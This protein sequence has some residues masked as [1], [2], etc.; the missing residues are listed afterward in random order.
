MRWI[1][2]GK[3]YLRHRSRLVEKGFRQI[4]GVDYDLSHS[5]VLSEVAFRLLLLLSLQKRMAIVTID[6]EKS[7]LGPKVDENLYIS[8]PQGLDKMMDIM[9]KNDKVCKIN[10]AIYGLVQ[11]AKN[12]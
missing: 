2:K 7:F 1:F 4:K 3:N 9:N 10:R 5:P 8:I 11:A 12:L 6:T